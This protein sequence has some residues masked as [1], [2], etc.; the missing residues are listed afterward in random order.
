[1]HKHETRHNQIQTFYIKDTTDK[2]LNI[3]EVK[4]QFPFKSKQKYKIIKDDLKNKTF[5]PTRDLNPVK[6]QLKFQRPY[7]SPKFL[8][9]ECDL[10]F[11]TSKTNKPILYMFIINVNTKFLYVI[12]LVGKSE[13][14][15]INAFMN[16]FTFKSNNVQCPDGIRINNIRFDGESALNSKRLKNFFDKYNIK[17]YSNP[18]PYI[19]KNRVVDRV[20]RTI[21]TSFNNLNTSDL[22][23]KQHRNIMQ[24]IVTMYN[25]SI[26]TST[27]I[28]PV[29]MTFDDEMKYIK[30]K[31]RELLEQMTKQ[32][33]EGLY[34]HE[35]GDDVIVY[36]PTGKTNAYSKQIY[37]K[38]QAEFVCYDHGNIVVK[39]GRK[40]LTVPIY[41][42]RPIDRS[43]TS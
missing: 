29:E 35:P 15:M 34:N 3:N 22:S 38:V 5:N 17:Y 13:D 4:I 8:N 31:D 6:Q 1:M 32:H 7:Y 21:R 33:D 30:N 16:L 39:H 2:P 41:L 42:T 25:N 24:Q 11:F 12:H 23:L 40:Q 19:N 26:H 43:S 20:I 37:E 36:L 27:G 18:S 28:K 10:V 14:E 9:W